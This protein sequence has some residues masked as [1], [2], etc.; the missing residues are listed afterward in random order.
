[1][2]RDSIEWLYVI[3]GG[4]LVLWID[5]PILGGCYLACLFVLRLAMRHQSPAQP[6]EVEQLP[7]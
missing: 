7:R 1:M 5:D 4:L 6:P 3:L 2:S